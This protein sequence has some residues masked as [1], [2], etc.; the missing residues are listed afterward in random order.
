VTLPRYL[1]IPKKRIDY[2]HPMKEGGKINFPTVLAFYGN[3]KA[4]EMKEVQKVIQGSV[5][6]NRS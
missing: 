2:S 3:V 6:Q 4:A 5:W 1:F